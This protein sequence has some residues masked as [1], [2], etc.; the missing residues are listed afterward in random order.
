MV[1]P[2]IHGVLGGIVVAAALLGRRPQVQEQ[3]RVPV[4]VIYER[5]GDVLEVYHRQLQTLKERIAV[6]QE[7]L[8]ILEKTGQTTNRFYLVTKACHE[9]L[10]AQ[11]VAL[12]TLVGEVH[13]QN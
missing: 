6:Y 10:H 7:T 9:D 4:A 11:I 2:M 5:S 12:D 3:E 1:Y 8:D 13:A